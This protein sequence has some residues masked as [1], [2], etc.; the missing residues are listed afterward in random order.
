MEPTVP[1]NTTPYL[2][3]GYVVMLG[4]LLL[5]IVSLVVRYRQARADLAFLDEMGR[6]ERER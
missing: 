2:I 3:A 1:P 5:Y 4:G 6:S